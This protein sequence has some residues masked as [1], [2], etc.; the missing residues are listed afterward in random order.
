MVTIGISGGIGAGKSMVSTL[1]T[2]VGVPVYDSDSRSKYLV[3]THPT[4]RKAL[5]TLFSPSIYKEDGSIDR[6]RLA[7]YIFS[8]RAL[9]EQVN[10]IIHPIVIADFIQWRS[11]KLS[12][13][14]AV[15]IE[16]ALL[17]QAG[18][19]ELVDVRLT[20]VSPEPLRI[21]R[22]IDRSGLSREQIC[23]RIASQPSTDYQQGQGGYLLYNDEKRSI[24]AQI[25]HFI[26][27]LQLHI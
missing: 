17:S 4:I 26:D 5:T 23:A 25:H 18:L 24:I 21:E 19:A 13:Y 16:S 2:M 1:L 11:L 27:G 6:E 14:R 10:Q 3:D 22:V 15:A 7:A 20:V 9:L 8:D 12:N